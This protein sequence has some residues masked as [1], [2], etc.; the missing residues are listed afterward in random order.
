MD[1]NIT[2]GLADALLKEGLKGGVLQIGYDKETKKPVLTHYDN[3]AH[4]A[5]P[6]VGGAAPVVA[7]T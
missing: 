5:Q 6:V 3:P 1:R 7:L 2:S 4:T